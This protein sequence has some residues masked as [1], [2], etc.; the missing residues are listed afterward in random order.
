VEWT[1][2]AT[3]AKYV[4]KM[5]SFMINAVGFSSAIRGMESITKGAGFAACRYVYFKKG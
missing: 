4:V 3:G 5:L 1:D 2:G